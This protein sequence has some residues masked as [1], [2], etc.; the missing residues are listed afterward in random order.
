MIRLLAHNF[1]GMV[2]ALGLLLAGFDYAEPAEPAMLVQ[3]DF[4][5]CVSINPKGELAKPRGRP[6]NGR[7]TY[8]EII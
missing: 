8:S 3:A 4:P 6:K 2:L 1:I 5:V 7:N